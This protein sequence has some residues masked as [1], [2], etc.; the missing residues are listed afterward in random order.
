MVVG[1]CPDHRMYGSLLRARGVF[2]TLLR[3]TDKE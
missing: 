2:I 1:L 3:E